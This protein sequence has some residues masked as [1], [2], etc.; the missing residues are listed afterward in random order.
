MI[1]IVRV[2]IENAVDIVGWLSLH[3]VRLFRVVHGSDGPAGLV[4]S[5][6]V[7]SKKSDPW[8]TLRLFRR[9]IHD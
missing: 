6:R 8:T 2:F 9:Q 5:G 3:F 4:R 1:V 7:G